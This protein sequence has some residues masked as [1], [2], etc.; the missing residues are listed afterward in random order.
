MT[1]NLEND[2]RKNFPFLESATYLDTA[3]VGLSWTGQAEA[4]KEFYSGTK[5]K[6]YTAI[7]MWNDFME[8]IKNRLSA[9]LNVNQD[10]LIFLSST[11]EAI[12]LIVHSIEC[13]TGDEIVVAGDEYASV[14][15]PW[16]YLETKGGRV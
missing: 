6:G 12:N 13:Q 16:S 4:A 14:V 10:E 9:I 15:L 7:H 8:N 1:N 5:S 3:A 11:T 2:I